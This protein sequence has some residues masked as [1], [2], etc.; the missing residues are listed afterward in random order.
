MTTGERRSGE[1][2]LHSRKRK[3]S[4]PVGE[5]TVGRL[6]T[7]SKSLLAEMLDD[8]EDTSWMFDDVL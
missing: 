8:E 4:P 5:M 3:S 2:P 7:R 6:F 1:E